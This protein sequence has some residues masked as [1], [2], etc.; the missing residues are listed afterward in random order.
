MISGRCDE[1]QRETHPCREISCPS[2]VAEEGNVRYMQHLFLQAQLFARHFFA[3]ASLRLLTWHPF[4]QNK[5]HSTNTR[6]PTHT[7][8]T[9]CSNNNLPEQRKQWRL[10]Q[11]RPGTG[12]RFGPE[13]HA[14]R[15]QIPRRHTTHLVWYS[16]G[17]RKSLPSQFATQVQNVQLLHHNF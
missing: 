2:A 14:T 17:R 12:P 10:S 4:S 5:G 11:V 15:T 1:T 9:G 6:T 8:R 7:S 13:L 16:T 3:R